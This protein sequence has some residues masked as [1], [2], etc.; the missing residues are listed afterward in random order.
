MAR[1]NNH[2]EQIDKIIGDKVYSLRLVK[3]LSRQQ[4]SK[5]IG[6]THQ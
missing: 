3:G 4:L 5:A 1:K 2:I 6:V